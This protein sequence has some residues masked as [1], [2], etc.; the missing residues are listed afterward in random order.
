MVIVV[1]LTVHAY[2]ENKKA[3][4][5][6]KELETDDV[7]DIFGEDV[8]MTNNFTGGLSAWIPVYLLIGWGICLRGG[9]DTSGLALLSACRYEWTR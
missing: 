4:R 1:I 9:I 3:D 2:I 8:T 7:S 6:E 5:G